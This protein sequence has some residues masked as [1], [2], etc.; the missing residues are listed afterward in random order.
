MNFHTNLEGRIFSCD[1][2]LSE[3]SYQV[4]IHS[5]VLT[6]NLH[7]YYFILRGFERHYLIIAWPSFTYIRKHSVCYFNKNNF[8]IYSGCDFTFEVDLAERR[9]NACAPHSNDVIRNLQKI[10]FH[11]CLDGEFSS[12]AI[13]EARGLISFKYTQTCSIWR[14]TIMF[15][16]LY[17]AIVDLIFVAISLYRGSSWHKA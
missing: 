1:Y 17:V 2:L 9:R 8:D 15:R 13:S 7:E 16:Q 14:K 10:C 11:A 5:N 12:G 4:W 3:R 6:I